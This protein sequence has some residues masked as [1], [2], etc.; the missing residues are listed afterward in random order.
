MATKPPFKDRDK[1]K[2]FAYTGSHI[3]N[4]TKVLGG[5]K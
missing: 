2:M 3:V 4:E 1:K 5:E